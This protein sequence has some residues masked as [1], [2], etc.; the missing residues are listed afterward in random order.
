MTC[1]SAN[2]RASSATI[3][4][5]PLREPGEDVVA[6]ASRLVL[7]L[8]R[9][10]LPIQGPPGTGKTFTAAHVIVDLIDAGKRVGIM[11][12][13]HNVITNLLDM[14]MEVADEREVPINAMQKAD[15]DRACSHPDVEVVAQGRIDVE[16]ALA[17]GEVQLVAGTAWLFAS[18][19]MAD[20]LDHLVIDEAGQMA[21]GNVVAAGRAAANLVLVG[22]PQQLA[23]PTKGSHPHGVG[24]SVLEH[25]LAGRP[26]V[27]DDRGLFLDTTWRMHPD[28]CEFVSDLAYES[29]LAAH[30]NCSG[31]RVVGDDALG[32][33]GVRWIP[34]EH[35]GNKIGS[36]EEVAAVRDCLDSLIGREWVDFDGVSSPITLEGRRGRRAVQRA[37]Q[38]ADRRPAR[39]RA[40]RHRRQV[41]GTGSGG[42]D[43]VDGD[44]ERRRRATRARVPA[45]HEPPQRRRLTGAGAGHRRRQSDPADHEVQV[46]RADP[47]R[48]RP[49]PLRR[50]GSIDP[51]RER[52]FRSVLMSQSVVVETGTRPPRTRPSG[53]PISRLS[54]SQVNLLLEALL[55]GAFVTGVTSWA[56]GTG[57]ARWWTVAHALFGL[58]VL[59]LAPAKL[60]RSVRTGMR[61]RRATRWLSIGFGVL[62]IV[63]VA[64]GF[65]HATG[66]WF[67]VGYWSS[68]WTHFLAAFVL[69]P[70][71]IWHVVSR[72]VR[73]R[74]VDADR[75]MLLGG[76]TAAGIAAVVYGAQETLARV[77]GL[78]GGDRRFS[79]SHE[80]GSFDPDRMPTVQW[81]N[82]TA[83][84]TPPDQWQLR[85]GGRARRPRRP[86][87]GVVTRRG[88]GRLHR[89][90]V[91][92][93]VVGRRRAVGARRPVV[94][95]QHPGHVGDRL[96]A[97]APVGRR[98]PPV[99]RRRVQR[100][101]ATT[102]TRC[103]R[104]ADR[105]RPP[106]P[107]VGQVGD[108]GR[109]RRSPVVAPTPVPPDVKQAPPAPC[110]RCPRLTARFQR[111][112]QLDRYASLRWATTSTVTTRDS[113]SIR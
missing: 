49:L 60:R 35:T 82:D 18:P 94:G 28:V 54:S 38:Q 64:L 95:A 107:V 88:R 66:L 43:R 51:G 96:F 14:V 37:G 42:R 40:S 7:G 73:P 91:E 89:R 99:P 48:Q 79:G 102:R 39:R 87:G 103:A 72:P 2:R 50:A 108:R 52:G 80:I 101:T 53:F 61:R 83:P 106:R 104:P 22:D 41:P 59:V 62:V 19:G 16:D 12:N 58:T 23:Q 110:C 47:T 100:S 69:V 45:E 78:A 109:A 93:A 20:T 113:S 105:P 1:C 3:A 32:G 34:V 31:Q 27:A 90:L 84:S 63:T 33:S 24:V 15:L 85:I 56:V 77:G 86:P 9:S 44:V 46:A 74:K 68:L 25:V 10:Y 98:R 71:L 65:L 5:T 97:A 13:S 8:D 29:R 75:R 30:P 36:D 57:W 26:T 55:I 76:V 70:L 67:G 111:R 81:F 4:G 11:A 92:Q 17:A 6:A 21:L 112:G